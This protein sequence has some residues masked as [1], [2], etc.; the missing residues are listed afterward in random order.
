ML[1][2][3]YRVITSRNPTWG[4]MTPAKKAFVW[5]FLVCVGLESCLAGQAGRARRGEHDLERRGPHRP[6]ALALSAGLAAFFGL[7]FAL[8]VAGIV[9]LVTRSSTKG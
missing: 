3:A 2:F 8:I 1:I 6:S 4:D 5:V 9:K 7:I